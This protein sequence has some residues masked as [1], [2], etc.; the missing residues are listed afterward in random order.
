MRSKYNRQFDEASL[1]RL[2]S[3]W[4]AGAEIWELAW[5][6]N[7]A[8]GCIRQKLSDLLARGVALRPIPAERQV[9][10]V[11]RIGNCR[12]APLKSLF[13]AAFNGEA[14]LQPGEILAAIAIR[15]RR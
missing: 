6:F 15:A 10:K 2:G 4:N 12:K 14:P 7:C 8:P 5:R 9:D 1:R 13:S 11:T 3:A